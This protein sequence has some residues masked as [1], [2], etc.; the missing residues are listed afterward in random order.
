M[1]TIKLKTY[2]INM[3]TFQV[4]AENINQ[5]V[6]HAQIVLKNTLAKDMITGIKEEKGIPPIYVDEVNNH[7]T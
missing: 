4:Q 6:A 7:G 2:T 3:D 1:A 5:A